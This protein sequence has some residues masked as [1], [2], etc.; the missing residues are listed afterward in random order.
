MC[1]VD[2]AVWA[3]V[4]RYLLR[5]V[6]RCTRRAPAWVAPPLG[7]VRPA[8][9]HH[10]VTAVGELLWPGAPRRSRSRSTRPGCRACRSV[11]SSC[12][13]PQRRPGGGAHVVRREVGGTL[14]AR[15]AKALRRCRL[16]RSTQTLGQAGGGGF[17][18]QRRVARHLGNSAAVGGDHGGSAG[19]GLHHR[20]TKSLIQRGVAG[21]R[22]GPV[23]VGQRRVALRAE[24]SGTRRAQDLLPVVTQAS[25]HHERQRRVVQAGA[26]P[27]QAP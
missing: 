23:Q 10:L 1:A 2:T 16:H 22:G 15:G 18:H 4:S 12:D 6:R 3:R 11:R 21:D 27:R 8:V 19:H 25:Y 14:R 5:T 17:H 26:W 13:R 24:P 7:H 20:Q 9:D